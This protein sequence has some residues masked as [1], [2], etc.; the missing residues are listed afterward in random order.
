MRGRDSRD[1]RAFSS[2]SSLRLL[3][4]S[5]A[6]LDADHPARPPA[7]PSSLLIPRDWSRG[8]ARHIPSRRPVR[9][10]AGPCRDMGARFRT[11]FHA[12]RP[13]SRAFRRKPIVGREFRPG[14]SRCRPQAHDGAVPPFNF[15]DGVLLGRPLMERPQISIDADVH[16]RAL[17]DDFDGAHGFDGA[18]G[19]ADVAKFKIRRARGCDLRR[20]RFGW[21]HVRR[22][23]RGRP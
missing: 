9:H 23:G 14:R 18:Y 8:C 17:V 20:R 2:F 19:L 5:D 10:A 1:A 22:I 6:S 7:S 3:E 4:L 15:L 12:H 16:D 11:P 13:T 21:R